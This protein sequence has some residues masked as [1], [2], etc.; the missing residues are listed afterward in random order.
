ME[1]HTRIKNSHRLAAFK[2][3]ISRTHER[4]NKPLLESRAQLCEHLALASYKVLRA[5]QEPFS[6][7]HHLIDAGLCQ[8]RTELALGQ[9][10][11]DLIG[12]VELN[13][14][15]A[16]NWHLVASPGNAP[17]VRLVHSGQKP[18]LPLPGEVV[19]FDGDDRLPTGNVVPVARFGWVIRA[20][21]ERKLPESEIITSI[22]LEINGKIAPG[23]LKPFDGLSEVVRL[24]GDCS[25]YGELTEAFPAAST[26]FET[27][28]RA[29][30]PAQNP[31]AL[32]FLNALS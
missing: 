6:G 5:A 7:L 23:M 4:S 20:A 22:I 19:S 29:E 14:A 27:E 25:T 8:R 3:A 15:L 9:F 30:P 32:S 17:L 12:Q 31:N 1:N 21:Q 24:I 18:A 10:S 16:S 13:P 2:L 11:D 26:L 28:G